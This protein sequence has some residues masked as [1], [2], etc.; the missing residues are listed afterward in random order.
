M[1]YI[2]EKF[3]STRNNLEHFEIMIETK[4]GYQPVMSFHPMSGE[5][6]KMFR[7]KEEAE[8]FLY[9]NKLKIKDMLDVDLHGYKIIFVPGNGEYI[10]HFELLEKKIFSWKAIDTFHPMSGERNKMF[11]EWIDAKNYIFDHNTSR[12]KLKF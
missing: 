1:N 6:P 9:E 12:K 7:K 2:I 3:D 8:N 11:N 5:S 10:K 4:Y